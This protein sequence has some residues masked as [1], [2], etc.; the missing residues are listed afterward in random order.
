VHA[1]RSVSYLRTLAVAQRDLSARIVRAIPGASVYRHYGVVVDAVAVLVPGAEARRLASVRGVARVYPSVRYRPLLDTSPSVIGA[2]ILW[3]P[4]LATA[5]NGIK[6]G[7]VDDG[8]D[9]RHPFFAPQ[10]LAMP[11]GF[12]KGDRRYTSAKVI[13]ARAF[14]PP[15][16]R[17]R[18]ARRPFDPLF[19]DH[20]THV[21]GIAAG[22]HD[23][24]T[25][26]G[27]RV[28]GIAPKAYIGNYKV[29]TVPTSQFGLNGNSPEIAAGVEAAV[30]D[31]MDVINLSLGEAEIAPSRDLV[32]AALN[33]AA[34]A[35]VVPVVAAGNDFDDFGYGSVGS[36][37]SAAKAITVG[38][39]TKARTIAS[40]SSSGPTPVSLELKPEVSAPGV[41]ILSSV[42]ASFGQWDRFSGTSMA[43]PH[44]AGGAA[45][46]RQRHPA[47]TVAQIK[48][49]LASTGDPVRGRTAEVLPT[50]EGGGMIDLP[51][52][53]N[54]LVFTVPQTLSFGLLRR[55]KTATK[56]VAL[57]DA[58]GG[59][60]VWTASVDQRASEPGVSVTVPTSV[61]V[62]GQSSV[63]VAVGGAARP[64][65][66][67]G[68]VVLQRGSDARRIPYWFRVSVPSLARERHILLR[69]PGLYHGN[70][71]GKPALVSTYRYPTGAGAAPSFLPG[72]EQVFRLVIR[73]AVSN[74]GVVVVAHG[75][76]VRAQPRIVR[77]GDE[78]RLV[79][80]PGLPLDINP[81]RSSF[82]RVIP[83]AGAVRPVAGTYDIVFDTPPRARPG[84]FSFR[85]WIGDRTPPTIRIVSRPV[86]G[87]PLHLA[88]T[89]A[90]AGVDPST[91]LATIDGG[92]RRLVYSSRTHRATVGIAGLTRGTHTL[93]VVASDFQ[94][95]KNME[96][97]AGV[98]P[99]TRRFEARVVVR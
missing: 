46:L 68:F 37:G 29:L 95:T 16:L 57:A 22:D 17:W 72:P 42:P 52:A 96:D 20:G 7:I 30:R 84:P 65:D 70:T 55:D 56:F 23:T 45:L 15:G 92:R 62:P 51:R 35:G 83:V 32:V 21:A 41:S 13:V 39:A 8:V 36:P 4:Q 66:L 5:G 79:G 82:G 67:S 34:D 44:V 93:V 47:W 6:I 43:A 98:L 86:A 19:S 74:F 54:P 27:V 28:S 40:F 25:S 99:N 60:G 94:E 48:S 75:R 11:A 89:D 90:G 59:A 26:F 73:R 38:A 63:A 61:L 10:G 81:Y 76:R 18:Y 31:G 88:I 33:G 77:A 9:V 12:P 24:G 78:D 58:G 50:R 97:V 2:P 85:V 91:L 14:A 80:Y 64:R 69:G 3:G 53:D 71:R 87:R 49:A 1:P